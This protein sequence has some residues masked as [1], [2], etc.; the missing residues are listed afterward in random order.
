MSYLC[1]TPKAHVH[2]WNLKDEQEVIGWY[3]L[4]GNL[5]GQTGISKD[6]LER[7]RGSV[8][9]RVQWIHTTSGLLGHH[10]FCT[11]RRLE[12]LQR[13]KE[14]LKRQLKALHDAA[15]EVK[16]RE[17]SSSIAWVP[18]LAALHQTK[19][20][21]KKKRGIPVNPTSV[22]REA[23]AKEKLRKTIHAARFMGRLKRLPDEDTKNIPTYPSHPASLVDDTI[24][25]GHDSSL[26]RRE[27][28]VDGDIVDPFINSY[29]S[30]TI[31]GLSMTPDSLPHGDTFMS[32]HS[33]LNSRKLSERLSF[34]RWQSWQRGTNGDTAD[35]D[36]WLWTSW[37]ISRA[38]V[39][40]NAVHQKRIADISPETYP[41]GR[42][43]C[44]ETDEFLML[45]PTTP[46]LIA[47]RAKNDLCGLIR[48]RGLFSKA[49]RRS[50]GSIFNPGGGEFFRITST[51]LL[52]LR[53]LTY[54]KRSVVMIQFLLFAQ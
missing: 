13:S 18:T 15:Q 20:K 21:K 19:K 47:R 7:I 2:L 25:D 40:S 32:M 8:R 16:E 51:S 39:N 41:K 33:C 14:G 35:A 17:E 24:Y 6:P 43:E 42:V 27:F 11:D 37:N 48:S 50:L 23:S 34:L 45:P 30:S 26:V 52:F 36:H 5:S 44:D 29:T 12:A 3:P 1:V 10:L 38:F 31:D 49:A 4:V 9:L 22:T 46:R 28:L 53:P 54:E